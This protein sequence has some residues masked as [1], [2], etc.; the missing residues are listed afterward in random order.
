MIVIDSDKNRLVHSKTIHCKKRLANFPVPS[1]N[2]PWPGK[3]KL[4]PAGDS[5]VGNITAGDG[6]VINLFLQCTCVFKMSI[7]YH[8]YSGPD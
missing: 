1:P 8:M 4:F 7:K 5:L 6:K 2:S 3:I